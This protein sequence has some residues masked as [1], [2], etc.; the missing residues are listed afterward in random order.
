M[1]IPS[2][3]KFIDQM[4]SHILLE[5]LKKKAIIN[6]KTKYEYYLPDEGIWRLLSNIDRDNIL[7]ICTS[8]GASLNETQM[9]L[10]ITNK[11]KLNEFNSRDLYYI[12][13]I[14]DNS[15]CY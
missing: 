1:L 10:Q 3:F 14:R 2:H 4:K 7:K 8:I 12:N 5:S 15:M 11:N 9:L 6:D 13:L